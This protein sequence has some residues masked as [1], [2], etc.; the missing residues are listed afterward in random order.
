VIEA[1]VPAHPYRV[2][3]IASR[4]DWQIALPIQETVAI[5]L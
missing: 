2:M 1:D 5:P 4:R 3:G